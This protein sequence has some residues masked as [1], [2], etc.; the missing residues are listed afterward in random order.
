M[1]APPKGTMRTARELALNLLFQVDVAKLSFD[2]ALETAQENARIPR[3]ALDIGSE[4]ARGALEFAADSDRIVVELAPEWPTDRQP[5]VDRN[6]LRLALFELQHKPGTPFPVVMD[7]AVEL[8]KL[9][10]TEDS[11]RFVNGV[12]AGFQRQREEAVVGGD[13][14][15]GNP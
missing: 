8:A 1:S 2:E 6:I 10:S 9:Y 7:E 4:L 14:E 5:S 13:R 11:G 12:L 15:S 3:E